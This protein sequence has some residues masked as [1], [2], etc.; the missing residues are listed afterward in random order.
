MSQNFEQNLCEVSSQKK[1]KYVKVIFFYLLID[2][3][4]HCFLRREPTVSVWATLEIDYLYKLMFEYIII[5]EY[6]F[7]Y[8]Y[9]QKVLS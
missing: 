4:K 5:L 9:L 7:I 2:P 6:L 8:L 1:Q 3:L